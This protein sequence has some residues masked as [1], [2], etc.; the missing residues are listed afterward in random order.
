MKRLVGFVVLPLIALVLVLFGAYFWGS[1][2]LAVE[3]GVD[4]GKFG[5]EKIGDG[6]FV[7]AESGFGQ[8]PEYLN[9]F[10]GLLGKR[11]SRDPTGRER[12][13]LSG[14]C[15]GS[16]RVAEWAKAKGIGPDGKK[17]PRGVVLPKPQS[18]QGLGGFQ[19]SFAIGGLLIVV[20]VWLHRR[21]LVFA[22]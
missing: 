21:R 16:L 22:R 12:F 14:D 7:T 9:L 13:K 11:V 8:T 20:M 1:S 19:W 4:N 3:K 5:L 10:A 18:G 17:W 6:W 15:G 2:C